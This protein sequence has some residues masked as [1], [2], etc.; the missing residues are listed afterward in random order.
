MKTVNVICV[1]WGDKYNSEDVN[2]L[3]K[4]VSK[5]LTRPFSFY[6]LTEDFRGLQKDIITLNIDRKLFLDSYW[7]KMCIFNKTLY[8]EDVPTLYLDLDTIIQKNIDYFFDRIEKNKIRSCFTDIL[9]QNIIESLAP[10]GIRFK[11]R[12]LINSSIMGFIPGSVHDVFEKFISLSD[13]YILEYQGVCRYLTK[14]ESNRLSF[15]YWKK[16]WYSANSLHQDAH[17]RIKDDEIR[18]FSK[19]R[20]QS[21]VGNKKFKY[22]YMPEIPI[23]L[24]NGSKLRGNYDLLLKVFSEYYE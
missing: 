5:N 10:D 7:W 14:E 19:Y 9:D 6:C 24:L 23:C 20:K 15:F 4:M 18:F 1:K 16:D 22:Y 8:R 17:H 12:H 3:Y 2:R 13:Y 11:H 21:L